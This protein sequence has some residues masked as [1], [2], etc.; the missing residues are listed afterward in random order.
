[1]AT[2]QYVGSAL[3]VAIVG[4]AFF[5]GLHD[6]YAAA[7]ERGLTVLIAIVAVVGALSRLLAA[8]APVQAPAPAPA[9][10]LEARQ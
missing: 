10:A 6:G 1:M 9:A 4:V 5:G 8:P 7:F 3:G 2:A